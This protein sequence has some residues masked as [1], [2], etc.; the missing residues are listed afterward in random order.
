[1]RTDAIACCLTVLLA[2]FSVAANDVSRPAR[3]GEPE[4]F[5]LMQTIPID[6]GFSTSFALSPDGRVLAVAD[7]VYVRF[8]NPRTGKEVANS[9]KLNGPPNSIAAAIFLAFV[10]TRTVAMSCNGKDI[11]L[12]EYPSGREIRAVDFGRHVSLDSWIA[13]LGVIACPGT[14]D[15]VH[16]VSLVSGPK[17]QESWR[18][19]TVPKS[20]RALA[21]SPDRSELAISLHGGGLQIYSVQDGKLLRSLDREQLPFG[22]LRKLAYSPDG[23]TIAFVPE[24]PARSGDRSGIVVLDVKRNSRR[25]VPWDGPGNGFGPGTFSFSSDGKTLIAPGGPDSVR[26]YE[27][28]TGKLRHVGAVPAPQNRFGVSPDGKLFVS[29]CANNLFVVDWRAAKPGAVFGQEP[30]TLWDDLASPDS[31]VGYRA[32]VALGAKPADALKLIGGHLKPV[33]VPDPA[34]VNGLVTDL[35]ADDFA[36]REAAQKELA[37]LGEM[38]ESELRA[39]VKSASP[40][41]RDRAREVLKV[42][43]RGDHPERLRALR[44]VEVLE[45]MGTPSAREVLK[46]LAGGSSDALLTGDAKAALMRLSAF[47]LKP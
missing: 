15:G 32:V 26:L 29:G 25:T 28:Q 1:M 23:R 30:A 33:Q 2:Q 38:V 6:S 24:K 18:V 5:P 13:A 45:Y 43:S 21:F 11:S 10:D 27:V 12:R 19:A 35:A 3:P 34:V 39:A 46:T 31:A 22:E 17:W 4:P 8:W 40:E 41:R 20:A 14:R 37:R 36:T 42:L 9:W 44:C 47:G 7:G 16:E